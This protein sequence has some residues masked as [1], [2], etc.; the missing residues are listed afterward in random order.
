M[1]LVLSVES[2]HVNWPSSSKPPSI[3]AKN[4][5]V[6]SEFAIQFATTLQGILELLY[7]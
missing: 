4:E 1:L 2:Q 5:I 3:N 6:D 7:I